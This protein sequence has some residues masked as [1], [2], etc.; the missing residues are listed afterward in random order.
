MARL[1]ESELAIFG[2]C[3]KVILAMQKSRSKDPAAHW[4]NKYNTEQASRIM[5]ELTQ[6][7][8]FDFE[9]NK[10]K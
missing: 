4:V 5:H 10:N 2:E 7:K 6:L 8:L 1:T 3:V 9:K